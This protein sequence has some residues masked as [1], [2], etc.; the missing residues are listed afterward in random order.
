[1]KAC[2]PTGMPDVTTGVEF[3]SSCSNS[4]CKSSDNKQP[5]SG[6]ITK[7]NS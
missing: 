5:S 6:S 4:R 3:L 2:N 1:M 7:K